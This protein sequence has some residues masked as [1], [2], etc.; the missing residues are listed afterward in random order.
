MKFFISNSRLVI[1]IS[2]A[3]IVMGVR[4]IW[5]LQRESIPPVDFARAVIT[6]V[7][8]GSSS[9]EVEELI[10]SKIENEIRSV[11]H[12]KDVHSESQP[13]LSQIRIRIDINTTDTAKVI[14]EL[15]KNLQNVQDLPPEV[16]NPPRLTHIDTSKTKAIMN[17][18]VV[19]PDNQRQRDQISFH[20]KTQLERLTGIFAIQLPNY[21]KRELLVLLSQE[22][23]D[24]HYISSADLISALSQNTMDVPAGYLE[25]PTTQ[26]LVRTFSKIRTV[27]DLEETI[28]RSNFSGQKVS[29]KDVAQVIDGS[30]KETR[31]GYFHQPGKTK[32]HSLNPATSLNIMKTPQADTLTLISHIQK[33]LEKF[34]HNLSKEYQVFTGFNEGTNIKRRLSSVI[35]NAFT[36]LVLIFIVFFLFLPSKVG[37]MVS[38]SLPLSIL[39]TFAVLPFMGISFNAITMLAFVICIGMLIDNSVVIAEYYSRLVANNKESSQSAAW[40]AVRQFRKPITATV[41]TTI[42]AFLPMLVTT[43]VMGQFIQWIPIVV[44]LALLMS[45]FESFCLLPNR[46]QWLSQNKPSTYQKKMFNTLLRLENYFE[47][48]ITKIV[49]KKYVSLG[50]IAL[51]IVLTALVFKFGSQVNLFSP[52]SPEFYTAVIEPQ[53]NTSLSLMDKKT[54]QIAN[55]MREVFEGEKTIR[56]MSV[57]LN[58]QTASIL[59]R[60]KPSVLRGLDYKT[61]LNQLRKINKGDLKTLNFNILRGGPPVGKA[62]NAAIQANDRKKI[63]QFIDEIQPEIKK[64]PGLI[65][66]K[67]NPDTDKGIEYKIHVQT[68]TLARL[69]LDFQSVGLALRTALEGHIITELTENNESFYIRVRHDPEQMSSLEHLRTIKIRERFGRL[70]P[71]NEVA[72]IREV[73]SEPNKISYNFSPVIFL[74]AGINPKETTSMKVNAKARKI[75][76]EKIKK[77]PSLTFKMIG[78][79]EATDESM[80]SLISAAILA[81]FS[82]FII[83]IIL[84]KSFLLSFLILTC[85]PLGLIGVIWS[86]F[87][88]QRALDFFAMVGVVGLSGVV[89]NSAI[90]LVSFI[91][92]LRKEEPESPLSEI[93]IQASKIRFRPIMITNLTT[94][95]GFLPT[96]YGIAGFEPLLMPM[97]LA[98]FWGL[99][100]ATFLTL[101]WVPCAMLMIEDGKKL[102]SRL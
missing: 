52:K 53:A 14:N 24:K 42:V 37:L 44:T 98:L 77:Y 54:K 57:Q 73:P 102:L 18:Y 85:I 65:N 38:F 60:V 20:L 89:V 29:V 43:G 49:S 19:G 3:F 23:M 12:L 31:K 9:S 26:N 21:R 99:L 55:Q 95:G 69:G 80:N 94:L 97:T 36:G 50:G 90:I 78:E 28:V 51:L 101:I 64:I 15:H 68:E 92:K 56:W 27:R 1:L 4:G 87:F 66:L 61:I 13:G 41:L 46:L 39:G 47:Q 67:S 17:L 30:E 72:E 83:L 71:L 6:T 16:L 7:Y 93:V 32:G 11:N 58:A 25:A 81:F 22:K 70:I 84:F 91:L 2:L 33:S 82:I 86:F 63:R 45:L 76:K 74:E 100:T 62:L 5:N 10:T 8:P 48:W 40:Q 34:K 59:L 75:I 35:N 88:H 96:A 79:Q